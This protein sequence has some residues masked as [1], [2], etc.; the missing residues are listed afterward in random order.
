MS[1]RQP[2]RRP[3]ASH[4]RDSWCTQRTDVRLA[5]SAAPCSLPF[6]PNQSYLIAY[7]F[8][9]HT[10]CLMAITH[11]QYADLFQPSTVALCIGKFSLHKCPN[12]FFGQFKP[13][14][15]RPQHQNI[16]IIMFYPL[17]SRVRVVTKPCANT[18]QFGCRN[19]SAN[20]ATT[21]QNSTV[22]LFL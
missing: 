11:L 10:C 19:C 13:N 12:K 15:T 17:V 5:S 7:S 1:L 14:H 3:I 4:C 2:P 18:W 21:N 22:C 8:S 9:F 20:T 6:F 16:H